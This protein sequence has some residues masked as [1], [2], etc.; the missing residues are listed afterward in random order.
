M[1]QDDVTR[2]QDVQIKF[3]KIV[4]QI[5]KAFCFLTNVLTYVTKHDTEKSKILKC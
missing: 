4:L 1:I 3:F 2:P 5:V